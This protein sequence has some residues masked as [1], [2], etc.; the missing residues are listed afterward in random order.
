M[1]GLPREENQR[2]VEAAFRALEAY[3][4][5]IRKR[6]QQVL[7]QLEDEGRIGIAML[8]G[9]YHHD[10]GVN[11]GILEEFQKLGYPIF[12]QS[13]LPLD[14]DLLDRLFGEEVQRGGI[15]QPLDI[16]DVLQK[17][18]SASTNHKVWSAKFTARHPNLVALELS[19]FKC[20]HDAP[21]DGV[22]EAIIER[23]GTL[24]SASKT[25]MKT[26]QPD[27]FVSASRPSITF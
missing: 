16:S 18:F 19:S 8:G 5:G 23:S 12:E 14:E 17:S 3:E 20:G 7:D 6:A 27:R 2:A 9:P 21:I 11:Q 15:E 13:T 25:L 22:I 24:T 4:K 10:P 1:L 26:K